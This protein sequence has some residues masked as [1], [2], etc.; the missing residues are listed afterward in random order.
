M[1]IFNTLL[2]YPLANGLVLFY[3]ILFQNLGLAII[4]FTSALKLATNP[5]TKPYMQ[6]MKKMK[7][8]EPLLAKLKERHQGDKTKYLQAQSDL[9]K[10]K[11]INP[12]AGC[13]PYILQIIILIAFFS[14]F[15]KVLVPGGNPVE[16]LNTMLYPPLQFAADT[17]INTQFLWMNLTKPDTFTVP[18][19][20]F[21][22]P[23]LL[24]VL[25]ALFQFVSAKMMAP[26]QKE[27][28]KLAKKTPGAKDDIQ[29]SMQKSMIYTF[30]L[31]TLIIGLRFPS[32]LALYWLL[33]S[34]WQAAQQYQT[35]GWGGLT[36]FAKRIGIVK[37]PEK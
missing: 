15:N 19:L 27:E 14:M 13:L 12:G 16:T 3:N 4:A 33:F 11:G 1:N 18:G 6:S 35:S 31:F 20:P 8:L 21:A 5:L 10:Q 37:S 28:E 24:L 7:E 29:V 17:V 32:G 30:P 22:L 23:G 9:Y 2:V 36:P 34:F 26:Y 25:A